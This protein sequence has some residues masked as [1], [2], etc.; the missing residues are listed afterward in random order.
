VARRGVF[1]KGILLQLES[2]IVPV[3]GLIGIGLVQ[4]LPL[5]SDVAAGLLGAPPVNSLSLNP[6]AT[7]LFIIQ[8]IVYFVFSPP[9]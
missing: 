1:Q 6:Y 8:L 5:R 7:R 2:L 3:L 4:L 9:R